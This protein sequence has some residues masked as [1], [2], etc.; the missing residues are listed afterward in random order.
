MG[1]FTRAVLVLYFLAGSAV[2]GD[3]EDGIQFYGSKNYGKAVQSFKKAADQ[4]NAMAQYNL[5]L[6][7]A[8]GEGLM[9]D[10]PQALFWLRKAAE[11][12]V[13]L[14]YFNL[15]VMYDNGLGAA[16]D[17]PQAVVLYRQA[18][19]KGV[20]QAQYNLAVMYESGL[21]VAQDYVQAMAW[22]RKAAEQGIPQAQSALGEMYSKGLGVPQDQQKAIAWYRKSAEQ[23]IIG[24]IRHWVKAWSAKDAAVYLAFY[25]EDFK[26]LGGL[27]VTDWQASR[28]AQIEKPKSI[29]VSISDLQINFSDDTHAMVRFKQNYRSPLIKDVTVKTLTLIK[30]SDKWLI[31][32]EEAKPFSSM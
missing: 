26:T 17:Y 7:Y 12:G 24:T 32:S 23:E 27:S 29:E 19:E 10:Y 22:Y 2:A 25:A 30:S 14:A 15:G 18:A 6:M 11:R 20:A 16:Q 1:F 31:E 5:G 21:G 4:E 28:R 8:K 9:Q 3:F 13:A